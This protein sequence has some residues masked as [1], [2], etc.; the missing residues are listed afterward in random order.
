LFYFSDKINR[1]MAANNPLLFLR[2]FLLVFPVILIF[3]EGCSFRSRPD[4]LPDEPDTGNRAV[5][6]LPAIPDSL[7]AIIRSGEAPIW[8][9]LGPDGPVQ[10]SGPEAA[11]EE[12]FVPWPQTRYVAGLE[13]D[14]EGRL[15]MAVNR[16]GFLAWESREDGLALY[17]ISEAE[18][19]DPYTVAALFMYQGTA[20]VLL[21]EDDFFPRN[22]A[23]LHGLDRRLPASEVWGL[24]T[25]YQG[26]TQME[27]PAF[28]ALSPQEGWKVDVLALGRDGLWYYRG[29]RQEPSRPDDGFP[30]TQYFRT[31]DLLVPGERASTGLFRN[32]MRPYNRNDMPLPIQ[33][34]LKEAGHAAGEGQTLVA[35][36]IS[37]EFPIRRYFTLQAD[38]SGEQGALALAGFY[39]PPDTAAVVFPDGNGIFTGPAAVPETFA[40]P[41]LPEGFVYTRI[42][43]AG[44][45]L[46]ASWEEQQDWQVGAAGFMVINGP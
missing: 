42:G 24:R 15:I 27:I 26:M 18:A 23:V 29:I 38:V 14:E 21:Y 45:V 7:F 46:I 43:I 30:E 10:I 39:L 12:P 19:W 40:L 34:V 37:Q 20:A 13:A 41:A 17:R 28:A 5:E 35:T 32:A 4:P 36:V 25:D 44:S 8:F 6:T 1:I 33:V 11:T 22:E 2:M 31:W 16:D 3:V 9:E